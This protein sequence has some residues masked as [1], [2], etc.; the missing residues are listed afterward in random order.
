MKKLLFA[1]VLLMGT[2]FASCNGGSSTATTHTMDSVE[3]VIDSVDS[4]A[5]DSVI[6]LDSIVADTLTVD[7]IA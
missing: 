6:S 3:V 2:M 7:T 1:F 5:T 4:E